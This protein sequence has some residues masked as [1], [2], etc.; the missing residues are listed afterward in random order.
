MTDGQ[1]GMIA[2]LP[3]QQGHWR[4]EAA[5]AVVGPPDVDGAARGVGGG[6]DIAAAQPIEGDSHVV[7]GLRCARGQPWEAAVLPARASVE[8]EVGRD[9]LRVCRGR[10]LASGEELERVLGIRRDRRL[11][12][13][14]VPVVTDPDVRTDPR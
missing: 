1:P 6:A 11:D 12:M 14:P 7:A 3:F 8:R 4:R 2:I 13:D 9:E 10:Y 5:P